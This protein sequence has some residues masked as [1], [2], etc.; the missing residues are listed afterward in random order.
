MKRLSLA[1]AML[2]W[3]CDSAFAD[4]WPQWR[5]PSRDGWA[6][7]AR[8]P[9]RWTEGPPTPLWRAYVGEGYSSPVISDGRVF[10]MGREDDQLETCLCFEAESGKRIWRL[11][12]PAGYKPPDLSAGRGPKA[13]PA[14]DRDSAYF[15][16][17]GGMF[18]CLD[19]KSGEVLWKRDFHTDYWG[20][21][22]DK[23]GDDAWFP[24]CGAATSPLVDG[25]TVIVAVGG[26]KAGAFA[27]FD[28]RNGAIIWKTLTDRSSYAS[29]IMADL[30]GRRQLV[31]FTGTRMV[32]I[33][34][35]A[36]NLLW[37]YPFEASFEQTVV[38]PV[39]WKDSVV[40]GGE[41]KKTVALRIEKGN[42]KPAVAWANEDLRAYLVTPVVVQDH[43]IGFDNREGK[44]ASIDLA[45]GATAWTSGRVGKKYVSLVVT[46]TVLLALNS[47]GELFVLK[48]DAKQFNQ[49][50]RWT[51]SRQGGTWSHLAV[52]DN[53][54]F[55]KD[56]TELVCY[57]LGEPQR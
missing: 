30:A 12:Y 46:P 3:L 26:K 47:E 49:I 16:G 48:S 37:E 19:C 25:E 34:G 13:T 32:G 43:L 28:R 31:G 8:L 27:A 20:V 57:R 6:K 14:V 55:I 41:Q 33:D 38:G 50:A 23:D 5:G 9:E 29:P 40:V 7:N 35:A 44:L 42:A 17:L 54:L 15:L 18:H 10:I 1:V 21:Q 56:R 45:T 51:V 36:H 11:A 22:K 52:A 24:A 53:H 39:V 2:L 4:D